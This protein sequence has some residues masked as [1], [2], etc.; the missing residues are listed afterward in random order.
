M[1]V[2]I[3]RGGHKVHEEFHTTQMKDMVVWLA[4]TLL[5]KDPFISPRSTSE[6][7]GLISEMCTEL[8]EGE[9]KGTPSMKK[10]WS[11]IKRRI[12]S[13]QKILAKMNPN[14]SSQSF[15]WDFIAALDGNPN[16]NGFGFCQTQF[17]DRLLGNAERVSLYQLSK[18][19]I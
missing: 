2:I 10:D 7:L 12:T 18:F 19:D 17:K 14:S 9:T 4:I 5:G 8:V 11:L 6:K 3:E 15:I 13:H 16:L 1:E